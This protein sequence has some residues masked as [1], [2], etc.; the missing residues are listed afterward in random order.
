M[1]KSVHTREYRLLLELLRETRQQARVTQVQLADRLGQTQ[2]FISKCERGE[3]RL[4]LV[5][6]RAFCQS[7]G[8]SLA[9]FVKKYEQRL[10]SRK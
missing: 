7:L 6:L 4:D 8:T 1:E 5:Q 3:L 9:A 10:V 2:S